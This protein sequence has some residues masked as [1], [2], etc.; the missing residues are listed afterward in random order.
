VTIVPEQEAFGHLHHILKNEIYS[1][2]AE[3]QHGHVLAPGDPGSLPL[4]R[5][6]LTEVV[7]L[8]PG[9]FIHLGADETFELGRGRSRALADSIGIGSV[10]LGFMKNIEAMLRPVTDKRTLFWHDIMGAHRTLIPQIP[11]GMIAVAW[12]YDARDNMDRFI[13]P[14]REAGL[15]TWVAP[16][17]SSWNR[18]YP[19][20]G[21]ALNNIRGFARDGQAG[22]STGILN[23]V[24]DDD[25]DA[26]FEQTWYGVL[27][28]A[29]AAWQPGASSIEQFQGAYGR[30]FHGD[31]AGHVD[32]AQKSLMAAHAAL[33]SA[34][35]GDGGSGLFFM[36]PWSEEGANVLIRARPAL[37]QVRLH[38]ESALVSLTK[39]RRQAHLR[40]VTAIEAT[41]L[42][43]RR[44]DW[45]AAKFQFADAIAESFALAAADT[46]RAREHLRDLVGINGRFQ[47]M[48][49]GYALTRDLFERAWR[50]ENR[51]YWMTNALARFDAE[52]IRWVE[53]T[54]QMELANRRWSRARRVPR[55][56]D[57]G[58]PAVLLR[59]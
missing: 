53:R 27:F 2:L 9:P 29:A 17:V 22:G 1:G 36:D 7:N 47:D 42:G 46:T 45:L 24:W 52:I 23:T 30:I 38:A 6:L 19:N 5:D 15:E 51:P 10:Y 12:N 54:Q 43:A 58:I 37:R 8:F 56:E 16:G 33:Q 20:F 11:K 31:T 41:E 26:I 25:G 32:A 34:R 48:R 57:L 40:E 3:T 14:F 35:V 4:M 59:R 39:A 50:N 49:D 21:T 18:V 55:G 44:L 13:R 28:G